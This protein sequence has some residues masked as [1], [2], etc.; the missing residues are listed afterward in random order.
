[1]C[2]SVDDIGTDVSVE[3][4]DEDSEFSVQAQ[5]PDIVPIDVD[6]EPVRAALLYTNLSS[7]LESR[8]HVFFCILN[9]IARKGTIVHWKE[10]DVCLT[11][12]I[13]LLE[14]KGL[15]GAIECIKPAVERA[16]SMAPRGDSDY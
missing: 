2:D 13:M 5:F 12:L 6:T 7:S 8:L 3:I 14:E 9:L 1:M 10:L 4:K 16:S 11:S 15:D